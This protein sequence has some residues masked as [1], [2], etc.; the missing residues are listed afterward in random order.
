MTVRLVTTMGDPVLRE[1]ATPIDPGE[2][3]SQPIQSLIDDLI[4]TMRHRGVTQRLVQI[5]VRALHRHGRLVER[6]V[7]GLSAVTYQHEVDH[8]DGR[9]FVDL[10]TD[11]STRATWEQFE[12]FHS[13]EFAARATELVSRFG[14]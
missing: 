7:R 2:L 12:R 4:E 14:A 9:L 10:V 5:G 6:E 13:A 8:L 1:K 11:T 3:D